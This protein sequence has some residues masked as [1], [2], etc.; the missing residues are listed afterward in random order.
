MLGSVVN[1]PARPLGS[2]GP[3][4]DKTIDPTETEQDSTRGKEGKY[5]ERDRGQRHESGAAFWINNPKTEQ[6]KTAILHPRK[7][8]L[9]INFV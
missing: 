2:H 1:L 8:S 4:L 6:S 9:A 3:A 7:F 5:N